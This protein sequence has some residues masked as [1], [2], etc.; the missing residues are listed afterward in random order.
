MTALVVVAIALEMVY[1]KLTSNN[2]FSIYGGVP[3]VPEIRNVRM[4]AQG[5]FA[6]SIMAGTVDS[7]MLT[8]FIGLWRPYLGAA[9][10][11]TSASVTMEFARASSGPLMS[12]MVGMLGLLFWHIRSH[13]STLRFSGVVV[14]L[15]LTTVMKSPPYYLISRI[16]LVGAAPAFTARA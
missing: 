3:E 9:M 7:A 8:L 14:Y 6:H 15:L 5:L 10:L 11:G 16:G 12:S 4:Q 2:L 1:E 13:M